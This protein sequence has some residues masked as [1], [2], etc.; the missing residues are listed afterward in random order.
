MKDFLKENKYYFFSFMIPFFILCL[1]YV[2]LFILLP[3]G[4]SI[5]VSDMGA[6]YN[7]LFTYFKN[8]GYETFSFLKGFGNGMLGTIAY[9]LASPFNIITFFFPNDRIDLA[10]LLILTLKISLSGFTMYLY[11]KDEIKMEDKFLLVFSTSYALMGYHVA[12]FINIMWLDATMMLPIVIL[13]LN[14]LFKGKPKVYIFSLFYTILTNYYIAY[15]VCIFCVL[16]FVYKILLT[17]SWRKNKKKITRIFISFAISSILAAGMSLFLL[18]PGILEL[19]KVSRDGIT[20]LVQQRSLSSLN[21]FSLLSYL[22]IGARDNSIIL[23]NNVYN[24]YFG[25]INLILLFFYFLNRKISKKEKI[26][27]FFMILIFILSI[28]ISPIGSVWNGFSATSFFSGRF[29]FLLTFFNLVLSAKSFTKVEEIKLHYYFV[30]LI[31]FIIASIITMVQR[32]EYINNYVIL[33]NNGLVLFY[34]VLLYYLPRLPIKRK[35]L[36]LL[37]IFLTFG[38]LLFNYYFSLRKYEFG[39]RYEVQDRYSIV[40]KEVNKIKK[41]DKDFYRWAITES[42][43]TNDSFRY[44]YPMVSHFLSTVHQKEKF[45]LGYTSYL[46]GTNFSGYLFSNPVIDSIVGNKYIFIKTNKTWLYNEIGSYEISS[47]TA[48]YYNLMKNTINVYENPYAFS[49]GTLVSNKAGMCKLKYN[50][51]D[52]NRMKYQNDMVSCLVGKETN[53]FKPIELEKLGKNKYRIAASGKKAFFVVPKLK[54]EYDA[55]N[56]LI[57]FTVNGNEVYISN[58]AGVVVASMEMNSEEKMEFVFE[59]RNNSDLKQEF[60]L[61]AYELDYEEYENYFKDLSSKNMRILK[62]TNGYIKGEI[63]VTEKNKNY[64][65]LSTE[66]TDEWEIK[67][68]GKKVDYDEVFNTFVGI[69]LKEGKHIIEMK[70]HPK[71]FKIGII[72]SVISLL[73]TLIYVKNYKMD[74]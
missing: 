69:K 28:F 5:L 34:L 62:N 6:Q 17:Y 39:T 23:S 32:Y 47:T 13:G 36:T 35:I 57:Q 44:D 72:L 46:M 70:F 40:S 63:E 61:Y 64:L 54:F 66:Y 25:S 19:Q 31:L 73:L 24:V 60:E 37:I 65:F 42:Y 27:S 33:A 4:N 16:Y 68:D 58:A 20:S 2:S 53:V 51:K 48:E 1:V 41:Q 49:L 11:L 59:I 3:G 52:L 15:M 71:G 22:F 9:Y 18:L 74:L 45:F 43:A 50:D 67:V 7:G 8:Y 26:L 30:F 10:L 55:A 38:E 29:V 21:I 56:D 12:F 14:R